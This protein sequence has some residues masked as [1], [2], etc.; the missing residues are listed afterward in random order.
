MV[1]DALVT[2]Q[3][4]FEKQAALLAELEGVGM[5]GG[6]PVPDR[7]EQIRDFVKHKSE[8]YKS[9]PGTWDEKAKELENEGKFR[10]QVNELG[11]VLFINDWNRDLFMPKDREGHH[12]NEAPGWHTHN[13]DTFSNHVHAVYSDPA[14]H[15]ESWAEATE[16][17]KAQTEFCKL[18]KES[19]LEGADT[20]SKYDEDGA[21]GLEHFVRRQYGEALGR[22]DMSWEQKT[23]ELQKEIDKSNGV[24]AQATAPSEDKQAQPKIRN[25]SVDVDPTL[26]VT[27]GKKN[28][29]AELPEPIKREFGQFLADAEKRKPRLETI[30]PRISDVEAKRWI[31]AIPL[32]GDVIGFEAPRHD[33]LKLDGADVERKHWV[34]TTP[35][36]GDVIGVENK[37]G[38][39]TVPLKGDVIGFDG[40]RDKL[41][42]PVVDQE[43]GVEH[44]SFGFPAR[45]HSQQESPAASDMKRSASLPVEKAFGVEHG[46]CGVRRTI[47]H[48]AGRRAAAPD[49]KKPASLPVEKAFGVE[50]GSFGFAVLS[51]THQEATTGFDKQPLVPGGSGGTKSR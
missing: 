49:M 27:E 10:Q 19:A 21:L 5:H 2:G 29:G 9:H 42:S 14:R 45:S 34:E 18:A 48:P 41:A 35:L 12:L 1:D 47:A 24:T 4:E 44:G 30:E 3:R 39:E 13:R 51:P 7:G 22:E 11:T 25:R 33:G 32:K 43:F 50:H 38:V 20:P 40:R 46:S 15:P 16:T 6:Q 23:A 28:R 36:K 8:E 26:G 37:V 31:E 17:L